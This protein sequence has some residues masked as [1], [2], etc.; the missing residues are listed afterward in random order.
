MHLS[1]LRTSRFSESGQLI[2]FYLVCFIFSADLAFNVRKW[3]CVYKFDSRLFFR[4][5]I[6]GVTVVCGRI[7]PTV[8]WS[9]CCLISKSTPRTIVLSRNN[10]RFA[11]KFFM[12]LQIAHWLH[13]YAELYLQKVKK[14]SKIRPEQCGIWTITTLVYFKPLTAKDTEFFS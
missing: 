12:I 2:G 11:E 8:E 4:R 9:A 13:T 7:I 14:V 3:D 6:S 1:K 10:Y 5:G